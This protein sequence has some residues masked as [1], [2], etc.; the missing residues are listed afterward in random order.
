MICTDIQSI[1]SSDLPTKVMIVPRPKCLSTDE[2][3]M[4]HVV[5][6]IIEECSFKEENLVLLQATSPLRS[7]ADI[8]K[9]LALFSTHKYDLVMSVTERDQRSAKYG[10]LQ[11][12]KFQAFMGN[13][14]CFFNR[15]K[16]PKVYGPNGALYI[17][18]ACCFMEQKLFPTRNIGILEMPKQRSLDID[19]IDDLIAAEHQL[20]KLQQN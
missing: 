12:N 5:T 20:N 19:T 9:G 3:P 1:T 11:N 2:T 16:L 13:E 8:H 10:V 15:Q 4:A 17:F 7:D 6:H 14:A 18:K